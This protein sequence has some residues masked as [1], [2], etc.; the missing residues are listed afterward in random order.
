MDT[1]NMQGYKITKYDLSW[2][3]EAGSYRKDEWTSLSDVGETF[4]G[5]EFTTAE[6]ENVE[7]SYLAAIKIFAGSAGIDRLRVCDVEIRDDNPKWRLRNGQYVSLS[8]AV[9]ICR[10]MLRE[11]TIWCRLEE[12]ED[13]YVHIGYDYYMYIGVNASA[14]LR[15]AVHSVRQLGLFVQENWLSPYLGEESAQEERDGP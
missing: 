3:G 14:D 12:G 15:R 6:Y 7:N 10:E 5:V 9:E 1:N 11:G 13:F 8:F 2:Y 4:N